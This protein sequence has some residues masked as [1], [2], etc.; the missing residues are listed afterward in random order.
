MYELKL[1]IEKYTAPLRVSRL[2]LVFVVA[3]VLTACDDDDDPVSNFTTSSNDI[4]QASVRVIHAS[5]D[6]PPVNVKLDGVTAIVDLDYAESSNY[7]SIAAGDYDIAVEGIIPGGNLDVIT[8]PDFDFADDSRTTIIAVNPV[9]T[10]KPLVIADSSATP[11][12]NEIALRVVHASPTAPAVDVYLTAPG[13]D[14]NTVTPAFSFS[15]EEDIDAG[16]V[17]AGTAQIRVTL[18][19]TKTVVYD[20]G[21]VDLGPFAGQKLLLAALSTVNPTSQAAAPISILVA[22][23]NASLM[24]YDTNTNS[25]A[26]VVHASPDAT[27][28]AGGDVEVFATSTA[29][30]VSPTELIDAFG[31]QGI[32]PSA[33]THVA[34]PS[35]SYVFDVAPNTN[36][37]GDSVYTSGSLALAAGAEY[38]VVAAGRVLTTPAFS[39]LVSA[40]DSRS[41]ATQASVKVIHAAPAAG[42][43]D[44]FVTVAGAFSVAEVEAN[45]AGAPLLDDFAFA[46]ITGYVAVAPGNYDIRVVAGG[47][48]AINVENLNLAAGSVSTIV[49]RGPSE[50]SG[51]PTD[52]GVILLTN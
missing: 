23:D 36:T 16:A 34:V 47:V 45:M 5:P 25:G 29:L 27:A 40:D 30:P 9:A 10:I 41:V 33:N 44:V 49:A 52:F 39:L 43:V 26:R 6:A 20:T 21:S 22:T 37:I 46:D 12:A 11:G 35:G 17:A 51:M 13:V 24:L 1:M 7:A 3:V 2:L 18:A 4:D 50:P 15:F 32:V 38:T 19:G 31:Y 42:D 28:A 8:V 48:A 14:I